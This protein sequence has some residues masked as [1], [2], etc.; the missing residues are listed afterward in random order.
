MCASANFGGSQEELGRT[1]TMTNICPQNKRLNMGIWKLLEQWIRTDLLE[2]RYTEGEHSTGNGGDIHEVI[3]VTGPA[4]LPVQCEG[5]FVYINKTIGV[6]PKLIHVPTHFFKVII[7]IQRHWTS[8]QVHFCFLI[9]A[10]RQ[11]LVLPWYTR[12]PRRVVL[13]LL[14][15]SFENWRRWLDCSSC[16]LWATTSR[17]WTVVAVQMQ[18]ARRFISWTHWYN[19]YSTMVSWEMISAVPLVAVAVRVAQ[20]NRSPQGAFERKASKENQLYCLMVVPMTCIWV[21]WLFGICVN[22]QVANIK[23]TAEIE[24]HNTIIIFWSK[25]DVSNYYSRLASSHCDNIYTII[26]Q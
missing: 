21:Q 24:N 12:L 6:Y 3:I 23:G 2:K 16:H 13:S 19:R 18:C 17:L 26:Q 20:T 25:S 1:F 11:V 4:F 15:Y 8:A 10:V 9:P 22:N 5:E 7:T 14:L